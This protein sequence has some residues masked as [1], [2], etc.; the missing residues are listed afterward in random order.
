MNVHIGI[1]CLFTAVH[2]LRL[3]KIKIFFQIIIGLFSLNKVAATIFART[4]EF[5]CLNLPLNH[6]NAFAN[7]VSLALT[8]PQKWL[9]A[10]RNRAS[11]GLIALKIYPVE[12]PTSATATEQVTGV[13]IVKWYVNPH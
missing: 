1:S 10:R 11:T 7:Q 9:R 2:Q 5:A 12:Q 3:K 4:V 13:G 8:V 6:P